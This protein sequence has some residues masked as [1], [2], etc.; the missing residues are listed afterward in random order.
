M[1]KQMTQ[2]QRAQLI[3]KL[4]AEYN[5]LNGKIARLN[6]F[7]CDIDFVKKVPDITEQELMKGQLRAMKTYLENLRGRIMFQ[8]Y[9]QK[10]D[11]TQ[12][13]VLDDWMNM[14]GEVVDTQC[15]PVRLVNTDEHH[16]SY[17]SQ[18]YY[19][20]APQFPQ[21]QK[22]DLVCV[23]GALLGR[24]TDD[25]GKWYEIGGVLY[26]KKVVTLATQEDIDRIVG[27]GGIDVTV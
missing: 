15:G 27:E 10:K 14:K 22:G 1:N 24:V 13:Q 18:G 2:E 19:E 23:E 8:E 11:E 16:H 9:H 7:L 3:E 12:R 20:L 17:A 6:A 26:N 25:H 5:D 4:R 21:F